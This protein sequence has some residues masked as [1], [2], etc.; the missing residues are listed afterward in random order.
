MYSYRHFTPGKKSN[1]RN[2]ITYTDTNSS[3]VCMCVEDKYDKTTVLNNTPNISGSMRIAQ[4][5]RTSIGG[6]TRFGT[7]RV[8]TIVPPSN[9]F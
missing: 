4:T 2:M 7:G 6:T 3:V 5:I 1:S 8:E 9:T